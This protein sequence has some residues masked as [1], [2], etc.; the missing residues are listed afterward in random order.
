MNRDGR[1][2]AVDHRLC[3]AAGCR[4][5]LR[6]RPRCGALGCDEHE[7]EQVPVPPKKTQ[8]ARAPPVAPKPDMPKP[9]ISEVER[10]IEQEGATAVQPRHSSDD[11]FAAVPQAKRKDKRKEKKD[12]KKKVLE[13]EFGERGALLPCLVILDLWAPQS[14]PASLPQPLLSTP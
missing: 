7:R 12:K 9:N 11:V 13:V 14:T 4:C 10:M 1:G 2:R 5:Q 8:K 6:C 3:S